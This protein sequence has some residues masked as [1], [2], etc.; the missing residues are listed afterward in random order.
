M[1]V[2]CQSGAVVKLVNNS[3]VYRSDYNRYIIIY[4]HLHI[5][6]H[7]HTH[8]CIH[9]PICTVFYRYFVILYWSPF[10]PSRNLDYVLTY[11]HVVVTRA[12]HLY[13]QNDIRSLLNLILRHFVMVRTK[14]EPAQ[15]LRPTACVSDA[16]AN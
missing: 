9:I 8:T 1:Q 14:L 12:D 2:E 11:N 6:S 16:L 5:L 15:V 7:I 3:Y 4:A 10:I 13:I